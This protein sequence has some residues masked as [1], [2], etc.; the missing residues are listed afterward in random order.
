MLNKTN[1]IRKMKKKRARKSSVKLV[2]QRRAKRGV[3]RITEAPHNGLLA[4]PLIGSRQ[5]VGFP[6]A[7]FTPATFHRYTA[8][9]D[10]PSVFATLHLFFF[11]PSS[12]LFPMSSPSSLSFF[13]F[14]FTSVEK[15]MPSKQCAFAFHGAGSFA[16]CCR[17][18]EEYL[19]YS[20]EGGL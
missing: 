8:F 9:T 1:P 7:V 20:A 16:R 6:E 2:E 12:F 13:L 14:L 18:G 5:K 19:R 17:L 4:E 3:S 10:A 11:A 15:L